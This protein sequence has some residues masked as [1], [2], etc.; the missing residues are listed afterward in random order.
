MDTGYLFIITWQI[1]LNNYVENMYITLGIKR[2]VEV[3]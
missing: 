1:E 2:H 3:I